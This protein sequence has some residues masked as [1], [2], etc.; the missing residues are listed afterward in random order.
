[1]GIAV[2]MLFLFILKETRLAV[3]VVSDKLR[4]N[5][6][7]L[8]NRFFFSRVVIIIF[9]V[10]VIFIFVNTLS[11]LLMEIMGFERG[12]YVIIMA[13]IVGVSMIVLFFTL[14]ALGIFKLRTLMIIS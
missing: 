2:L 6:E 11:V 13:L 8:F 3:F 1:M 4:E 7:S 14:F 10:S 5:S 12:E 9:S